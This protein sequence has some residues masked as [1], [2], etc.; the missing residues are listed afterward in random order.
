MIVIGAV[1]AA[2][3][4]WVAVPATL[5]LLG[6]GYLPGLMGPPGRP[7]RRLAAAAIFLMMIF[8]SIGLLAYLSDR[9]ETAKVLAQQ[10]ALVKEQVLKQAAGQP[11]APGLK[12]ELDRLI[13]V[14]PYILFGIAAL[15]A[16]WLAWLNYLVTGR[17]ARRRGLDWAPL[18]QFSRW[19][20]PWVLAY[21]FIFGLIGSLFSRN[22][23]VYRLAAYGSGLGLLLV[24]GMLYFVQGLAVIKFYAEKNNFGPAGM[25]FFI[26]VGLLVQ[27]VFWG[28]SWL[29]LF[30]TWFDFR[31]LASSG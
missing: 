3:M 30:D 19:Q 4:G 12:A 20:L 8:F 26:V 31:K 25:V 22:F 14:M 1:T 11:Q 5:V 29:G 13:A 15:S 28:M 10:S 24:F 2:I 6:L 27:L 18:P 7:G 23:G 16:I 17:L 9:V 21:G